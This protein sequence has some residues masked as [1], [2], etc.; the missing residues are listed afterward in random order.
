MRCVRYVLRSVKR[1]NLHA[2]QFGV[3]VELFGHEVSAN[4]CFVLHAEFVLHKVAH[5]RSFSDAAVAENQSF[6]KDFASMLS[7][8]VVRFVFLI[9]PFSQKYRTMSAEATRRSA[10][11]SLGFVLF[12]FLEFCC[13]VTRERFIKRVMW[14][15]LMHVNVGVICVKSS[16]KFR[17]FN[18]KTD[19]PRAQ[20]DDQT[21]Q[22]LEQ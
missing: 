14:S 13:F 2:R 5:Q 17:V 15:L 21:P 16:A 11:D 12:S 8:H 19:T 3:E 4:R 18:V 20:D 22:S 7:C 6:Q 1:I 9:L 10:T